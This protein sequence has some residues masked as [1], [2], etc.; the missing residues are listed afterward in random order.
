MRKLLAGVLLATTVLGAGSIYATTADAQTEKPARQE[1]GERP[2]GEKL[3]PEERLAK[4]AEEEGITVEELKAKMEAKHEEKLAEKAAERGITVEE[5][6]AEMEAK[7]E[8]KLAE[9]AAER[10]ITIEELKAEME[11]KKAEMEAKG[12]KCHKGHGH[13]KHGE[14]RPEGKGTKEKLAE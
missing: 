11:A 5:L 3:S 10:G 6:K 12:E 9:K 7:R 1:A 2:E 8:E 4:K 14:G 13:E